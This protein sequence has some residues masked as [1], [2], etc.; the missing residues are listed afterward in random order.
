MV[1]AP[2][3]AG[4]HRFPG[5]PKQKFFTS[6]VVGVV[7]L[8][9]LSFSCGPSTGKLPAT[10]AASIRAFQRAKAVRQIMN[11]YSTRRKLVL[12]TGTI[13]QQCESTVELSGRARRRKCKDTSCKSGNSAHKTKLDHFVCC[14]GRDFRDFSRIVLLS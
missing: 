3:L 5:V 12:L 13:I 10:S 1:H 7:Q 14:F 2:A 6:R 9:R 4:W 8:K 11:Q